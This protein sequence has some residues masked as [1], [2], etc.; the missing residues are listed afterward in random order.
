[1]L[2]VNL[3]RANVVVL[4]LLNR[5]HEFDRLFDV[6]CFHPYSAIDAYSELERELCTYGR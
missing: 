1:M 4:R 3:E 2:V 5:F 6:G